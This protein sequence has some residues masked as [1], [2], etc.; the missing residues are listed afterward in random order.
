[1][2][3]SF[4]N[5]HALE[6]TK[7]TR[8]AYSFERYGENAWFKCA[9]FLLAEG[10]TVEAVIEVLRS[11]HMRWAGDRAATCKGGYNIFRK[12]YFQNQGLTFKDRHSVTGKN[13]IDDMLKDECGL[14][15]FLTDDEA[16]IK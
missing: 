3:N 4:Q 10:Y 2:Y 5:I 7:N 11:K 1:M 15:K 13:C 14:A 12:Y 8:D 16:L 6:I 9:R